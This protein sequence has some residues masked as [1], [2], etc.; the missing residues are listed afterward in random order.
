[1]RDYIDPNMTTKEMVAEGFKELKEQIV[2]WKSEQTREDFDKLPDFGELRTEWT[3]DT[4]ERSVNISYK[5][6]Q[7]LAFQYP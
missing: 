2:K 7:T 5:K 6:I 4:E 1:M 3:F